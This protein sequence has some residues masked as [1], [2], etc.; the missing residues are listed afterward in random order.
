MSV[1]YGVNICISHDLGQ[2]QE[3]VVIV[4]CLFLFIF[5]K[6]NGTSV[7]KITGIIQIDSLCFYFLLFSVSKFVNKI[8]F[9]VPN[10]L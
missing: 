2:M 6:K 1:S 7:V 9:P 5:L 3:F 10:M 8:P 4:V